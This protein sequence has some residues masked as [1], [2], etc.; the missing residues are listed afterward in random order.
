MLCGACHATCKIFVRSL[1]VGRFLD[2][3]SVVDRYFAVDV[4]PLV[5]AVGTRVWHLRFVA[6][7]SKSMRNFTRINNTDLMLWRS[8]EGGRR[9]NVGR[10]VVG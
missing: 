10:N 7:L 5:V 4:L 1:V 8:I 6:T 2:K 9:L 3:V